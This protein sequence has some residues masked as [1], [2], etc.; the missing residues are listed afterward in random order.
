[1]KP[2]HSQASS[3]LGSAVRRIL[4]RMQALLALLVVLMCSSP[5]GS[6][7]SHTGTVIG[8]LLTECSSDNV[9]AAGSKANSDLRCACLVC[10]AP[11]ADVEACR[12]QLA[13]FA[14]SELNAELAAHLVCRKVLACSADQGAPSEGEGVCDVACS[15]DEDCSVY[16]SEFRCAGGFCRRPN[17]T[18][19]SHIRQLDCPSNM[20]GLRGSP[21]GS[22]GDFCADAFEVTVRNYETCVAD[23]ACADTMQGNAFVAG[24]DDYPIDWVSP[25]DASSYCA[26]VGKR[27]PTRAEWRWAAQNGSSLTRYPWG[28]VDPV[29]SGVPARVCAF[30]AAESCAVGSFPSGNTSSNLADLAGNV[31]EIAEDGSAFCV[32]GGSFTVTETDRPELES[33][34]CLPFEQPGADIGFRCVAAPL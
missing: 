3:R 15:A 8:S 33:S 16:G 26:H 11:C 13:G 6:G 34:S 24:R 2:F 30:D 31:A 21:D 9:C 29:A 27:V 22:I 20:V 1:M 12:T 19:G 14:N 5:Q 18:S 28:D 32:A 25:A 7:E 17:P 4:W 10:T 23:A